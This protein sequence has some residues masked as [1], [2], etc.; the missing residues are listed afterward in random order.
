MFSQ[1]LV[2]YEMTLIFNYQ[3]YLI[4]QSTCINLAQRVTGPRITPVKSKSN[5]PSDLVQGLH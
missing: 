1:V 4:T 2:Y 3:C 5:G